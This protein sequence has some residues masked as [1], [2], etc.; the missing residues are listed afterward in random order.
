MPHDDMSDEDKALFRQAMASI[1]PLRPNKK[2]TS[3]EKK[4]I[5]AIKRS[6][7]LEPVSEPTKYYLSNY[8]QQEVG[9]EDNLTYSVEGFPK[10][11]FTQLKNGQIQWEAR[12]DLHGFHTDNA[13]LALCN[14]I[15]QEYQQHHRCVLVIHGK[16]QIPVLKNLVNHWLKQ[17]PQVIAFHS[18]L[19]RHGGTGALYVLLKRERHF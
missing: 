8:Y 19:P 5:T 11:R 18:T 17:I 13:G 7:P 1:K 10:K 15:E 12:L 4:P 2:V 14:F 9:P 6:K 3:N 16:G